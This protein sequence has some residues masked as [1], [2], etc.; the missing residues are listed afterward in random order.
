MFTGII[1]GMG[2]VV[3]VEATSGGGRLII[4]A[5]G[6]PVGELGEGESVAVNGCCL[7]VTSRDAGAGTMTFDLLRETLD[8][9][10][11]GGLVPG[12]VVNL[13]RAMRLG[14]RLSGHLVQGHV[15]ATGE[16][17]RL[18][19]QGQDHVV[20]VRLARGDVRQIIP[21]GSIAFDGCSL[22]AARLDGDD[23]TVFIIPHTWDVTR[24][25]SLKT[26]DAVNVEFDMVGKFV[27]RLAEEGQG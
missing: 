25:H 20:T 6:L 19:R 1:E 5:V 13:E 18:E 11:L 12:G 16:I 23:V 24:L 26:G 10:N 7:T 21:R 3:E 17:V 8:V 15:D 9:T 22:T 14:D 27:R 4:E 2:R